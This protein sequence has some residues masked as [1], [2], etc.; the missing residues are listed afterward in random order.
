MIEAPISLQFSDRGKTSITLEVS[1]EKARELLAPTWVR[2]VAV[3][4]NVTQDGVAQISYGH[5]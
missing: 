5:G 1:P 3:A 2:P 4:L